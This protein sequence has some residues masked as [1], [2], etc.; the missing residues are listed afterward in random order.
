MAFPDRRTGVG[1]YAFV[2]AEN[3]SSE[4]ALSLIA[5]QNIA[6]PERLQLVNAL[7]RNAAGEIRTEILQLIAMNQLDLITP[8]ITDA[9]EFAIIARIVAGRQ[10]LRDRFSY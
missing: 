1:L 10:N 8:L 5:A 6:V 4:E 7:P 3:V 2:E 9:A